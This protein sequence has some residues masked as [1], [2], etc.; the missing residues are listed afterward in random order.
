M[1]PGD[2]TVSISKPGLSHAKTWPDASGFLSAHDSDAIAPVADEDDKD[3]KIELL[4][5]R[6]DCCIVVTVFHYRLLSGP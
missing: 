6:S 5:S 2:G 3:L 4:L 1:Q